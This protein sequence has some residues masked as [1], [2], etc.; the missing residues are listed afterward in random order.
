[1]SWFFGFKEYMF[2][3]AFKKKLGI[4]DTDVQSMLFAFLNRNRFKYNAVKIAQFFCCC[5]CMR[6]LSKYRQSEDYK[7][8]YLFKKAEL[9]FR[10]ELDVV[11]IVKTLRLYK[12]FA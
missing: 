3:K 11:R 7:E 1:M 2:S 5:F 10:Q 12:M 8:H 6:N 9:K 4:I